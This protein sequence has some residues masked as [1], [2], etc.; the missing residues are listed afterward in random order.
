MWTCQ[1]FLKTMFFLSLIW[2]SFIDFLI[3]FVTDRS[4][5]L[6]IYSKPT[7]IQNHPTTK[8]QSSKE[9]SIRMAGENLNLFSNSHWQFKAVK[10]I[11]ICKSEN[12]CSASLQSSLIEKRYKISLKCLLRTV[13]YNNLSFQC[14]A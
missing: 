6:I 11:V 1:K 12:K 5:H 4:I 10:I 2:E 14:K 13:L 7:P 3:L 8:H 9:K